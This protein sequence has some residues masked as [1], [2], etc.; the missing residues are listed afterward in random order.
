M[1]I[2]MTSFAQVMDGDPYE[3]GLCCYL[4]NPSGQLKGVMDEDPY[5]IPC[6]G[7]G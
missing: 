2:R 3:P 4:L 6:P 1:E 5:D 7:H